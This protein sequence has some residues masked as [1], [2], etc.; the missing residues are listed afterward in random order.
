MFLNIITPCSRPENLKKIAE[1][2]NIP[3]E[4]YRWIV[5]FDSETLPDKSFIPENCEAYSHKNPASKVGNAQRNFALDLI[6]T[7]HVYFNDDDT[8]MHPELWENIKNLDNDFITFFQQFKNGKLRLIGK[9]RLAMIDSHNYIASRDLIDNSRWNLNRYDADGLF[10][11]ECHKKSKK[12]IVLEK[13]L[14]TYNSLR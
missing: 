1:S 9:V 3:R 12:H 13:V 2:I 7:G 11:I 5:V 14:S 6:E 4:N 8:L 10:A